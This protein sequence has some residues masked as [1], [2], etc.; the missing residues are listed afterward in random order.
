MHLS[1]APAGSLNEDYNLLGIVLS[2]AISASYK[3]PNLASL[4]SAGIP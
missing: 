1:A 3:K 4:P 2:N